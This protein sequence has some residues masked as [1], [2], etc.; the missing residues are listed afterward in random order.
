MKTAKG[1]VDYVS[2]SHIPRVNEVKIQNTSKKKVIIEYDV[3]QA[4][5]RSSGRSKIKFKILPPDDSHLKVI[6]QCPC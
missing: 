6:S 1:S 2:G 4:F 5:R 3:P